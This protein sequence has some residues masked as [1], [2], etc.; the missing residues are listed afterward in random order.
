[1]GPEKGF[2]MVTSG[3]LSSCWCDLTRSVLKLLSMGEIS[4]KL[5]LFPPD[6][7]YWKM[8]RNDSANSKANK[9]NWNLSPRT[10]LAD[11]CVISRL[12]LFLVTFQSSFSSWPDSE[13]TGNTNTK[14]RDDLLFG[15]G[16]GSNGSKGSNGTGP[17]AFWSIM[18][19]FKEISGTVLGRFLL[20]F[21]FCDSYFL[22]RRD[23]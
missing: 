2:V 15:T 18:S 19:W 20:G 17:W 6:T 13:G 1:M 7:L 22:R 10:I 3:K 12:E 8:L 11:L 4:W 23:W 21:G 5:A 16:N 14:P 9:T